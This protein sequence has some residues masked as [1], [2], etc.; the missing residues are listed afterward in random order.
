MLNQVSTNSEKKV[1]IVAGA[2]SGIGRACFQTLRASGWRVAGVSRTMSKEFVDDC[3]G[4]SADL[5]KPDETRRVCAIVKERWGRIDGV[6]HSVGNIAPECPV[7]KINWSQWTSTLN[8]CLGTAVM[9]TQE[10]FDEIKQNRGAFVYISSVAAQKPY[11][12]IADYNGAKAALS[13][14]ARSVAAEL[15]PEGRAVSVSPAVVD[16]PLFQKSRFT[17]EEAEGWHKLARIGK[18]HEVAELV[19]FLM[20]ADWVTGQDFVIDGGML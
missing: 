5:T 17:Q 19:T 15:A 10:T 13:S 18:P 7:Q 16:T 1:V 12:G 14:F 6:V 20:S 3:M 8:L 11:P 4:L 2:S 9:L